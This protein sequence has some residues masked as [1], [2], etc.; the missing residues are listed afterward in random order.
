[1]KIQEHLSLESLTDDTLGIFE[2]RQCWPLWGP[3]TP[4]CHITTHTLPK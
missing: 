4:E 2:V 3:T 1:M